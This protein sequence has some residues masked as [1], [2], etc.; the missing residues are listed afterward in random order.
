M[1]EPI[2]KETYGVIIYQEQVMQIAQELAGYSLGGADL[3]RRAMGKKIKAEMDAQRET[4]IEGAVARGVSHKLATAIF[5][6]V[7]KFA[8]YGF[9]KAHATA[10]ALVAYQT[11]YLKANHPVEFF[12]A[13]MTHRPR[14]SGQA[15]RLPPGARPG[16]D[17]AAAARRQ[18]LRRR[19]HGRGPAGRRRDPLCAAPRSAASASRRS[20]RWSPS[21]TAQRPFADLFDLAARAGGKMLNRRLLEALIKAGA[22]DALDA[23]RRQAS[24]TAS[25]RRCA[26][27]RP[28]PSR[29]RAIR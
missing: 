18:P 23:N 12:A 24:G 14:Q 4:F 11:A 15:Q 21:A 3:L 8:G 17:R 16:R 6:Q 20:R 26:S 2:L 29:R 5:D 25:I 19:L 1:L 13:S 22:L 7:A 27:A 28:T 10:Y 9:T